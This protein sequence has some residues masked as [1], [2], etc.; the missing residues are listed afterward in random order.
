MGRC[1]RLIGLLYIFFAILSPTILAQPKTKWLTVEKFT[2][3]W[4]GRGNVVFTLEI[5][6]SWSDPGDFTRLRIQVPGEKEFV[7]EDQFGLVSPFDKDSWVPKKL[8]TE[9]KTQIDPRRVLVLRESDSDQKNMIV[10][11]GYGYASAPGA[12]WIIRLNENGPPYIALHKKEMGLRDVLDLDRD[13]NREIIGY[14]CLSEEFG[15]YLVTYDPFQVFNLAAR[16]ALYSL[17]L[18][19]LYNL[20]HYVWAIRNCSEKYAVL[21]LPGKKRHV[22][23]IQEAERRD[24]EARKKLGP[25]PKR[26]HY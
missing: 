18:S 8:L 14:P 12:L 19:K 6:E 20:E 15:N 9:S 21:E 3:D 26:T 24:E 25:N 2:Y 22:F 13:G 11:I 10:L 5:P 16:R 1:C 17:E 4:N 23:P 7:A